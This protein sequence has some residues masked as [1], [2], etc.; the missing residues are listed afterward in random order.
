QAKESVTIGRR[1]LMEP[2]EIKEMSTKYCIADIQASKPL[3]LEKLGWVELPQA[4]EILRCG[5]K[6]VSEFIPPRKM[7]VELPVI[8]NMKS[9]GAGGMKDDLPARLILA[10]KAGPEEKPARKE[11]PENPGCRWKDE[12][13]GNKQGEAGKVVTSWTKE[14]NNEGKE[15]KETS[16]EPMKPE[17][18]QTG[19]W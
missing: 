3:Y 17:T 7:V 5:C 12:P 6:P 16:T 14:K 9:G 18:K 4:K 13:D 8:E 1:R 11:E 19:L 2:Y 10:K 15:V